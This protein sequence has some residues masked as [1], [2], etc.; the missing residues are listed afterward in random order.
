MQGTNRSRLV[1]I[2]LT[3]A[4][5]AW[6]LMLPSQALSQDEEPEQPEGPEKG[7][8]TCSPPEFSFQWKGSSNT[9]LIAKADPAETFIVTLKYLDLPATGKSFEAIRGVQGSLGE[10]QTDATATATTAAATEICV[11]ATPE[12]GSKTYLS[13]DRRAILKAGGRMGL[14]FRSVH[15]DATCEARRSGLSE[16]IR[17]MNKHELDFDF[18][19]VYSLESGGSWQSNLE[20][21]VTAES[22][23]YSW[24]STSFSTRYSNIGAIDESEESMEEM[25]GDDDGMMDD[26]MMDDG[27]EAPFNPFEQ[28]GGTLEADFRIAFSPP[29][30]HRLALVLG[31]GFSS[32]PKP[33][34]LDLETRQ[35][36][37]LGLRNSVEGYNAGKSAESLPNSS[38]FLQIGIASDDLWETVILEPASEDG[39]VPAVISDESERY[40]LEAQLDVPN[41]GTKSTRV[42]VRLYAS[43]PQSGDGPS[44]IRVSVLASVDP[45]GWFGMKK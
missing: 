15:G 31:A 6:F 1:Q 21:A 32:V 13:V 4:L 18:G 17:V 39:M 27:E 42:A 36:T 9:T 24:L 5:L 29:H 25:M 3:L 26:G 33:S 37:F 30:L 10:C 23:W 40:V 28:G 8:T 35:R 16:P 19:P 14:A 34:G 44:D 45:R 41:L 2:P 22:R 43:V 20:V 38:G 11:H 12:E 7:G